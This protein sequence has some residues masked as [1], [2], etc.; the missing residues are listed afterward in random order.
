MLLEHSIQPIQQ[1]GYTKGKNAT[2]S[3]MII[4]AMDLL[5]TGKFQGFCIVSSDSDFTKLASRI[6]ESGLF[7]Y[8]DGRGGASQGQGPSTAG[9]DGPIVL[10][11]IQVVETEVADGAC[12]IEGYADIG[13]QIDIREVRGVAGAGGD[14]ACAPVT[15]IGPTAAGAVGPRAAGGQGREGTSEIYNGQQQERRAVCVH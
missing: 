2:D 1:F 13:R 5:Y 14:Y 15:G 9:I 3:A 12:R 4:D 7:V 6:R 8:G 11:G 10:R